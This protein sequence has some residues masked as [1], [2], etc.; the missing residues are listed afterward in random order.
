MGA[1][2]W[3]K[4]IKNST[5]GGMTGHTHSVETRKQQSI[6]AKRSH[7]NPE[8]K[9]IE[10]DDICEYGCGNV[11]NYIFLKGKRCCSKHYNSCP[12]KRKAFS[13]RTDHKER[14][15][16]SLKTRI[17]QGI[18]VSSQIKGAKTRR[19]NGFYDQLAIKMREKWATNP[20]DTNTR[21][22]LL[23][24]KTTDLNY[25]GSYE[26]KFLEEFEDKHGIDWIKDNISRGP[27]IWYYDPTTDTERLYISD[28]L[29]NNTVYEIKS[30]W[31]WN[32]NGNDL[33]LEQKNKAKLDA[34]LSEGYNAILVID[35]EQINAPIMGGSLQTEDGRRIRLY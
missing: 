27:N 18:T 11:A 4:G 24:Y 1:G 35:G 7:R 10:T 30:Y 20:W 5:G 28:F 8:P 9:K 3:N 17:E 15:E 22:P 34:C 31:T 26:F 19:E 29:I 6:S 23:K 13:E 14:N 16:R 32:K 21:C 12:G 25:Q 2:G 33:I